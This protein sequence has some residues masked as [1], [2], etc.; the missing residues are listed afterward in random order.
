MMKFMHLIS[1][2]CILAATTI[3]LSAQ[4]QSAD[5]EVV[6]IPKAQ[7]QKMLDEHQKLLEEMKEMKAF[8]AKMEESMKKPAASQAET[9][10][11]LADLEKEIKAT[12]Q[13][14]KESFP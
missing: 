14:A 5:K 8:K 9:D 7:Y 10:Q 11:A 6:T 12:K 13:M 3:L 2:A 4:D 1:G